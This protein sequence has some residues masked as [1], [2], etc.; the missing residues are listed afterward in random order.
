[1][2]LSLFI[3]L[4]QIEPRSSVAHGSL[5]SAGLGDGDSLPLLISGNKRDYL[6]EH[7]ISMRF[8]LR[9]LESLVLNI[10]GVWSMI[11]W[12]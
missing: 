1:M 12:M 8:N 9:G 6:R 2:S 5:L 10:V 11:N 4:C 7:L 3:P